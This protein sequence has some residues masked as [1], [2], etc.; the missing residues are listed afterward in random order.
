MTP[1]LLDR[2]LLISEL[3]Q[4]DLERA[5]TGTSLSTARMHV[6]WVLQHEGPVTQQTLAERLEV[7]PRNISGLVDALEETGY[8]R[9]GPHPTDRR[10]HLV[11]LTSEGVTLM[12]RTS[13]EH[14]E[15]SATLF[16]AVEPRD[17]EALERGL[18]AVAARFAELLAAA[19]PAH[20]SGESTP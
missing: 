13:H 4:R 8:V 2:L 6:L 1:T 7:T 18:D 16:E 19:M 14:A 15:L 5:F 17:R 3:F 10:A 9:R 11:A 20:P 12:E